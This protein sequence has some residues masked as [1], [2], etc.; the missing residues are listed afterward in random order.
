MTDSSERAVRDRLEAT[1][2]PLIERVWTAADAVAAE[3]D[4][5]ATTVVDALESRLRA[6]G[7]L[8]ELLSLLAT[9]TDALDC[10]LAADPVPA[11]PYL[12][13]TG[14]GPIL[15]AT[16]PER[17]DRL[18]IELRAFEVVRG[19]NG[20]TYRRVTG[21]NSETTAR[22]SRTGELSVELR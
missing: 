12:V 5:S 3:W 2:G 16:L 21:G 4:D 20:P 22:S 8:A 1:H 6:D 14:T 18:V 7:T 17:D 19:E 9:A 15:R 10:P 11:P 13:A